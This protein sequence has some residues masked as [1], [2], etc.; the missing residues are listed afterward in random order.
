MTFSEEQR[1]SYKSVVIVTFAV[2]LD[3]KVA[4][5]VSWG[6]A[7]LCFPWLLMAFAVLTGKVQK[8]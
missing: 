4:N 2:L 7:W 6:W 5:V 8:R 1:K 3:L